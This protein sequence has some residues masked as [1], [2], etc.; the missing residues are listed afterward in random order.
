MQD[1]HRVAAAG[2]DLRHDGRH[3]RIRASDGTRPRLSR[4]RQR[5]K[6]VE[7]RRD[8]HFAPGHRGVA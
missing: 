6:E 5:A 2:E 1:E 8:A 3:S 7:E 4:I